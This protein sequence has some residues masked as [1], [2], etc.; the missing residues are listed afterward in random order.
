MLLP[1]KNPSKMEQ[2]N[3]NRH[4]PRRI[5]KAEN[6]QQQRS[7]LNETSK[8]VDHGIC[9]AKTDAKSPRTGKVRSDLRYQPLGCCRNWRCWTLQKQKYR[10]ELKT[11]RKS[12][13]F[14]RDSH[15]TELY[16]THHLPPTP[17]P[18]HHTAS[19]LS[20]PCTGRGCS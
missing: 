16:S 10:A 5:K 4:K 7:D 3:L 15:A 20:R 13:V 1:S 6:Q 8:S 19:E 12:V 2:N 17:V 14:V 9:L 11:G 18:A